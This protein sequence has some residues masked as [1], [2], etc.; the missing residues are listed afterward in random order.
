M[1]VPTNL[2]RADMSQ[3]YSMKA[4][5]EQILGGDAYRKLKETGTLKD[6]K[7]ESVR[8]L[9]AIQLSVVSTVRVADGD[10]HQDVKEVIAMGEGSLASSKS[11]DET[12]ACLA[13][14]LT[15]LVF[16]Q[17]GFLPNRMLVNRVGLTEPNWKLDILRSVQY[18][19]DERQKS[20][21]EAYRSKRRKPAT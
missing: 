12:F 2:I 15:R 8:L 3:Y 4:V 21:L 20:K 9:K 6:W 10:W 5:L 1:R 13:A 7:K 19:Q 11:I 14:T 16:L 17:L 18:V